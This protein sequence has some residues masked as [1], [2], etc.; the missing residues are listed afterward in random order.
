MTAILS[1]FSPFKMLSFSW[2]QDS[3]GGQKKINHNLF[4][5]SPGESFEEMPLLIDNSMGIK[6]NVSIYLCH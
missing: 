2:S 3:N 1:P 5:R 6:G 4:P